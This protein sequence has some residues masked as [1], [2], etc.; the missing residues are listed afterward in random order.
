LSGEVR[1]IVKPAL[2]L[3]RI[4]KMMKGDSDVRAS[5][6]ISGEAPLLLC[7]ACELFTLDLTMRAWAHTDATNR[8][9]LQRADVADAVATTEM[10]DFLA[11]TVPRD[12]AN[13]VQH[14]PVRTG[15]GDCG[16]AASADGGRDPL[17]LSFA[18]P[19]NATAHAR[20]LWLIHPL[21][22]VRT[23]IAAIRFRRRLFSPL[24]TPNRAPC[25]SSN[26]SSSSSSSSTI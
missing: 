16:Q 20:R 24:S 12:E 6:M 10:F 14:V 13:T 11:D 21:C 4:K 25:S 19:T 22:S 2:P 15:A 3:A 8:R 5:V 17:G 1:L 7:K 18:R 23:V 26:S 9:T